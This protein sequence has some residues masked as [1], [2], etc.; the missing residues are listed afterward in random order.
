MMHQMK[1]VMSRS[2]ETLLHDALGVMSLAIML[3]VA[4]YLPGLF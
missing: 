3:V 4:L 2:N 1:E